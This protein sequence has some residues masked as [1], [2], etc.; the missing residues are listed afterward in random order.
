MLSARFV[1]RCFKLRFWRVKF[2]LPISC[3]RFFCRNV[4][5]CWWWIQ[6]PFVKMDQYIFHILPEDFW[7]A[8]LQEIIEKV[9]DLVEFYLCGVVFHEYMYK[10]TQIVFVNVEKS[11]QCVRL[12]MH[13]M[14]A[15]CLR[16]SNNFIAY[17]GFFWDVA[18][19]SIG[20]Y[21]RMENEGFKRVHL[22]TVNFYGEVKSSWMLLCMDIGQF[23]LASLH[24]QS[25]CLVGFSSL[26]CY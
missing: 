12:Y 4:N 6:D 19:Y 5:K 9:W 26:V 7:S 2:L 22:F 20:E 21:S 15:R 1:S 16:I 10:S 11:L 17:S 13:F 18:G 3:F 8:S 24:T 14:K 23:H 25:S